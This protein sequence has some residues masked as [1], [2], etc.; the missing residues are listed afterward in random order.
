MLACLAVRP[1]MASGFCAAAA[2]VASIA[3]T[4][5]SQ[6]CSALTA[7][8]DGRTGGAGS[9]GQASAELGGGAEQDLIDDEVAGPGESEGDDL[10]DLPGLDGGD[11]V[12]LLHS[13]PGGLVS[14]VRG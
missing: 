14:D 9:F 13:L 3:V 10:G 2:M 4:S 11:V 5:P 8:R 6:P 7:L 1:R 12:A